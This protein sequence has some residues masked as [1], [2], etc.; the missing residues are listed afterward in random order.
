MVE[1]SCRQ[2]C[3]KFRSKRRKKTSIFFI[4]FSCFYPLPLHN[5]QLCPD[6]QQPRQKDAILTPLFRRNF[7]P[8][9]VEI[10]PPQRSPGSSR[11]VPGS[12]T[13]PG[14]VFATEFAAFF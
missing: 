4:S 14:M 10:Y 9:F 8:K 12:T 1:L 2:F 5:S 13:G 3:S 11:R 7:S 6:L